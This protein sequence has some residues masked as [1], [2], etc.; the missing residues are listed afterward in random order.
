MGDGLLQGWLGRARS[1][2]VRGAH[3]AEAGLCPLPGLWEVSLRQQV[4]SLPYPP[5]YLRA[6]AD[7]IGQAVATWQRTL[8]APNSLVLLGSPVDDGAA[9]LAAALDPAI[10]PGGLQ[11]LTP[12]P[13]TARPAD[14]LAVEAALVEALARL[15]EAEDT[16]GEDDPEDLSRRSRVVVL[17]P[18][19]QCFLRCIG[20][21]RG[22]EWLRD[23]VG[24]QRNYFW[25]MPCNTWAWAFLNRV[26]QV[27]AYL[28]Q[29]A[30]LPP[31]TG[32]TLD[33]WLTPLAQG[34]ALA[35]GQPG[36]SATLGAIA[37][38][39]FAAVGGRRPEVAR[40]L[41]LR[42]LRVRQADL[43]QHP[44]PLAEGEPLPV[45]LYQVQPSLPPLPDLDAPDHYLLH[46]L[47]LH[48]VTSLAHLALSL[49]QP[50]S[51]VQVQVQRLRQLGLL[52]TTPQGLGLHPA[53]YP[54]LAAELGAN[55]FLVGDDRL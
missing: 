13:W 35:Q 34:W 6:V 10:A 1:R 30:G 21:W 9:V 18:L 28:N 44:S 40:A 2:L 11:W 16:D 14:P 42:S 45:P 32:A 38:P 48:G 49:G 39:A 4:R 25:L 12:L 19:E 7:Q 54:R 52:R 55:N 26:C 23:T 15:R 22:V 36:A 3:R 41:W 20:G 50:E 53:H 17:P 37:W 5:P 43:P 29:T 31:L 27:E 46:G 33:R 8:D 51:I 24:T 47:M